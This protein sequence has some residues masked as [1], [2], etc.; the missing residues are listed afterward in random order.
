MDFRRVV[1]AIVDQRNREVG[2]FYAVDDHPRHH[3]T[4]APVVHGDV[5]DRILSL[6]HI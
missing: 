1:V 6:I 2:L 4:F 5:I 3:R